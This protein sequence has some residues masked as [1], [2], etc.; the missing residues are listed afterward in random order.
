[1]STEG[2]SPGM[3][4]VSATVRVHLTDNPA[5]DYV[6]T[7]ET[8][9][10]AYVEAVIRMFEIPVDINRPIVLVFP[11]PIEWGLVPRLMVMKTM[12]IALQQLCTMRFVRGNSPHIAKK[13]GEVLKKQL[14]DQGLVQK[15]TV[16]EPI[17]AVLCAIIKLVEV[18]SM[19][20]CCG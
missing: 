15:R 1:V 14:V 13:K 19:G 9:Y 10:R 4:S 6:T 5:H 11:F 2:Y 18:R 16:A 17:A 3:Q 12:D 7:A 8:F 20:L